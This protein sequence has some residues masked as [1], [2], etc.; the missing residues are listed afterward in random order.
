MRKKLRSERGLTLV[1]L[2]CTVVILMLL[3]LMLNT[4]LQMAMRSYQDMT[5]QSEVQML[6]STLSDALADDLR[7][8]TDVT[9]KSDTESGQ[10][11]LDCYSSDSYGSSSSLTIDN[12]QVM[13]NGKRVLPAGAYGNGAYKL[14]D[15]DEDGNGCADGLEITYADG[16][17]KVKL[18]VEQTN[19]TVSAGTEFT[20][21]CLNGPK[22]QDAE[23]PP[24]EESG[25]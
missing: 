21:R 20:V 17:F 6:L 3:G 24:G 4:G 14:A 15:D 11:L 7:Y 1:E 16:L 9:T 8:A 2:L 19:G 18:K 10:K 12:G 13:A 25:E 5:A 23:D 22:I